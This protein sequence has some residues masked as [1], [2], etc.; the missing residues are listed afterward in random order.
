[1]IAISTLLSSKH[2]RIYQN[3]VQNFAKLNITF[4]EIP[5]NDIWL[6]DFMYV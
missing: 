6:R 1:M 2:K 4:K 5:S 3:L